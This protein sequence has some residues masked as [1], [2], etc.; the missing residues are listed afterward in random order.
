MSVS[1]IAQEEIDDWLRS[2]EYPSTSKHFNH[3]LLHNRYAKTSIKN[4]STSED[5]GK[6]STESNESSLHSSDLSNESDA[7]LLMKLQMK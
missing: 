3:S 1:V 2:Y 6:E 4:E 5:D 7:D